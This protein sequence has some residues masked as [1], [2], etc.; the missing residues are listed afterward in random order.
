MVRIFSKE[1]FRAFIKENNLVTAQDAQEV[2]K[3]L[4]GPV[5]HPN[6]GD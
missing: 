1:Q 4:F 5:W 6:F 3:A 2:V